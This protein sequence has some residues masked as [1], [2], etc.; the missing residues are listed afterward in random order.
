MGG[1][2]SA[3]LQYVILIED[4]GSTDFYRSVLLFQSEEDFNIAKEKALRLGLK[5]ETSYA[6]DD[7]KTVQW[8]METIESLDVV[9]KRI[10]DDHEVYCDFVEIP[11]SE[12]MPYDVVCTPEQSDPMQTGI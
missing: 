10:V 1:D 7:G 12:K 8:R 4:I 5:R 6:S 9:G 2:I 11:D 3:L